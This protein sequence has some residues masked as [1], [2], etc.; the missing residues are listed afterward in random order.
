LQIFSQ[1]IKVMAPVGE[2]FPDNSSGD[3]ATA[4]SLFPVRK[5]RFEFSVLFVR[6]TIKKLVGKPRGVLPS[7]Q[8]GFMLGLARR[9]M[10]R[11]RFKCP[12]DFV[13]QR[14]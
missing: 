12:R 14:F 10:R 13:V 7:S 3:L 1:L 2:M 11:S 4:L 6:R 9:S 8:S 5:A